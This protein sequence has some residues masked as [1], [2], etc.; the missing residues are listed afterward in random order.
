MNIWAD[1]GR[2][3]RD[4]MGAG[5]GTGGGSMAAVFKEQKKPWYMSIPILG[6]L[7]GAIFGVPSPTQHKTSAS[8]PEEMKKEI[9][10][11]KLGGTG[12]EGLKKYQALPT[13]EKER[14]DKETG[15]NRFAAPKT[16]EG[17]TMST[18]GIGYPGERTWNFHWAGVVMLSGD[19]RVTL[20]NYAIMNQPNVKNSDWEFQMYGSAD[21]SGQTFHEQHQAT[22]Q[23]GDAPTTM[24]VDKS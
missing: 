8:D 6:P 13:T 22:K 18:G 16:G 17:Y 11:E 19:D 24:Q 4:V 9:F 2:S 21:K 20:E 23:H 1:C 3:G 14:F 5:E 7:L 10:N 15:I 12:D